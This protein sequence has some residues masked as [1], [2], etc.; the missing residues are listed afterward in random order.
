MG[1]NRGVLFLAECRDQNLTKISYELATA[2][3]E[4][5]AKLGEQVWAAVV[6]SGMADTA[7]ELA[8]LGAEKVYVVDHPLFTHYHP[9]AYLSLLTKLASEISPRVVLMGH[10]DMGRDLAPRLAFALDA[11]VCTNVVS[12]EC[13]PASK[14][15]RFTRP[16]FGGKANGL[17]S[18]TDTQPLVVTVGQKV[19]KPASAGAERPAELVDFAQRVGV[20]PFRAS[21]VS[22]V[23]DASEGT[24]LEDAA[25]IISGG[26]G[27]GGAEGFQQ[28]TELAVTMGG[29]LGASRAPVDNGWVP[30]NLQVGLTGVVVSPGVYLAVGISGAS[31]HMAGC[32]SANVIIAI[33]RDPDA[34]I[35]QRA[36]YGV[37]AD[38]R[39]IVPALTEEMQ[40][41]KAVS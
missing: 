16:T 25:V 22:R 37:V 13:D 5:A 3:R 17:F 33:N 10:T 24:K 36:H 39:E 29:S 21:P 6:G 38:W 27:I 11:G 4:T 20:G 2:A 8:G 18:L 12:I 23:E 34:P 19:F 14:V 40:R 30:A 41:L 9:E 26:R 7:S 35:F 31:Q 1:E 15:L 32:S 28:L